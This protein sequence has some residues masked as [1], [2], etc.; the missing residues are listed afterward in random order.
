[1][2]IRVDIRKKFKDFELE[3]SFSTAGEAALAG[4]GTTGVLGASGS[5]KSMTLKCI[6]GLIKPDEGIIQVGGRTVFDSAAR[7]N[8]RPQQRQNYALFPNMTVWDNIAIAIRRPKSVSQDVS[9][10]ALIKKYELEG[11][12]DR[13]PSALSGGQQQRVALARIFAYE[14]EILLLDEPFSALDSFLRENMQ[15]ELKRM[16]KKYSGDVILVSHSR[17]E[18]F[19]LCDK[20]LILEDGHVLIEGGMREVFA[21][22]GSVTAARM[23]GCKNISR[24][25]RLS[26][27]RVQA[28]DWGAE[29]ETEGIVSGGHS[30]IGIRAHD[31]YPGSNGS[32]AL[33]IEIEEIVAAPFSQT[34][35]FHVSNNGMIREASAT[36]PASGGLQGGNSRPKMCAISASIPKMFCC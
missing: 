28:T 22:P 18:V 10:R 8:L 35:L 7:I 27:H 26:A 9:V 15:L 12:E 19:A 21:D 20:L 17:D 6:A 24:I 16:I 1:M 23:T 5:G 11:L 33:A 31:F 14:P 36:N 29:F 13:Y 3:V 32:N 34:I 30:H 4:S 2:S 25:R